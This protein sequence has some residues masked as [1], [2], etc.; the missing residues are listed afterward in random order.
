M[1]VEVNI[2]D[3]QFT[4]KIL[5]KGAFG[6]VRKAY[7]SDSEVAVKS[8][9]LIQEKPKNIIRE[10]AVLRKVT[11]KNIV[12]IMGY[13]IENSHFHIIM[14]LIKGYT[15]KDLIFKASIQEKMLPEKIIHRD[16]NPANVMVTTEKFVKICDLGVSKISELNTELQTTQ[17]KTK[18][19]GTPLNMA[20]EIFLHHQSTKN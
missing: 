6:E 3:L 12:H 19:A 4:E 9:G 14:D 11:H 13:A 2:E 7:W 1:A 18:C 20:P 17:E 10:L 8:I 16:I 5:G 15:L